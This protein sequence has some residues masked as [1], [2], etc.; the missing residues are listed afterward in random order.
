MNVMSRR[1]VIWGVLGTVL[2]LALFAAFRPRPLPVDLL[3]VQPGPMRVT[4]DAEG[5]TKVKDVFAVSAPVGG[6]LHRTPLKVG[7]RVV[8]GETVVATIEPSD[9]AFLDPRAQAESQADVE[10]A[11]AARDLAAAELERAEIEKDFAETELHRARE[12]FAK[13]TVPQRFVDEAQ[14][15]F[16]SASAAVT[17]ATASVDA[18]D[19]QVKRALA[20]L[21]EPVSDA[22]HQEDCACFT[23]SAPVDGRVLRVFEES[24]T[25]VTPGAPLLEI[26]DPTL[27]EVVADFLSED[28]VRVEAGRP[29]VIEG[30][31]GE[32]PLEASVRRVEPFG[33][34][35]L[36]ALG[37]EEQRVNV[38]FD[39]VSPRA[40]WSSLGH[41]YR[42]IAKVVVWEAPT[43]LSV[44]VTALFRQG[45]Q[46]M[47]FVYND[48]DARL[49]PVTV[50]HRAGLQVEILTGL[51]SGEVVVLNPPEGLT[52]GAAVAGEYATLRKDRRPAG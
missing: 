35:K 50:G 23:L 22:P 52:D 26:G 41:G 27:L 20:R 42:V 24:E 33:F 19:H 38:V 8:R 10:S 6:L 36:S 3:E 39:L 49:R 21:I 48:G 13:G 45:K 40:Q 31:G 14:R 4:V 15:A 9:P 30:W 43:V 51:E 7:D 46:W 29:A 25:V 37:I 5:I 47:L 17:A 18:R 1:F 16:R 11:E 12:L 32:A 44:P 28:A 34:T 2:L